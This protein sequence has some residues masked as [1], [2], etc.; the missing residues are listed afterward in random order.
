MPRHYHQARPWLSW[1]DSEIEGILSYSSPWS[2][3]DEFPFVFWYELQY[4][5]RTGSHQPILGSS[6]IGLYGTEG[7]HDHLLLTWVRARTFLW[8][9]TLECDDM[10]GGAGIH[11][12]Y[13]VQIQSTIN[14]TLSHN[15]IIMHTIAIYSS[16]SSM[17][18]I[19]E[20]APRADKDYLN[21]FR[22]VWL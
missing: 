15:I 21:R 17:A 14:A 18:V 11:S 19:C 4:P 1:W 10:F 3:T 16:F 8:F 7:I 13:F 2:P 12:R 20:L 5:I 9:V 6:W 22:F